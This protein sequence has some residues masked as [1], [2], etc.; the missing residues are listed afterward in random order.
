[1]KLVNKISLWF[2][3]IVFLVTPISM[4][5]SYNSI[6]KKIDSAEVERMEDVNDRVA[7]QL[8]LGEAPNKYTFGRP[9]EITTFSTPLPSIKTTSTDF[10]FYNK[11]LKRNEC[12]LTVSSFYRIGDKNYKIS[13]YNYVT[14]SEQILSGMMNALVWKMLLIVLAVG[15]TSR[16]LSKKV[17]YPFRKT[18]KVINSFNLKK[19]EKIKLPATST[20]EFQELNS[21]L[22]KM[23]D[24]AIEEY[25]A[26]KEF[27]ENA[28]HELQTP[29]AVLRSKLE[30]LSE[31]NIDGSQAALIG[32]MQNAIDKLSRINRSLT[33]LTKLE[34]QE[35]ETSEDVKFCRIAKDVLAAYDDWI[36]LKSIQ[37]TSKLDKNIP[38]KIH[39][40]L[41]EML[42]TNLLSNAIRHNVEG[43]EMMIEL[44]HQKLCVINTGAAPEIPTEELFQRFKKSN[45]SA[46]SIGLGLAI[47]KQICEVNHFAVSYKYQ[48]SKHIICVYF[49]ENDHEFLIPSHEK[50]ESLARA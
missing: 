17:F 26:V 11:E 28:S 42:I 38:L 18:M 32:D 6:K 45:Q 29:L 36:T 37:V 23:T 7:E 39:P 33:L 10:C 3:A 44:T 48:K 13:S 19:K 41:A 4:Y 31:T 5:I 8:T 34:N 24:K 50:Q 22:Q 30:L 43:G 20:K 1:M 12:R 25:A 47:V 14:K 49:D 15:I 46:E 9:I 40:T 35:F 21:F 16:I 27:S 2:I